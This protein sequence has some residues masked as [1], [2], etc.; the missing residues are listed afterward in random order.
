MD[1]ETLSTV[2]CCL[3]PRTGQLDGGLIYRS[4][5]EPWGTGP[6]QPDMSEGADPRHGYPGLHIQ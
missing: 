2:V 6:L 4:L 3:H 1:G 5:S